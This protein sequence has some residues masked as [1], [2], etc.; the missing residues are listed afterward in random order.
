M[1]RVGAAVRFPGAGPAAEAPPSETAAPPAVVS[2]PPAE[3]PSAPQPPSLA[4]AGALTQGGVALC[5]AAPGAE[6]FIAGES[7]GR[8]D[9][10]G[11]AVIGFNREAPASVR[12]GGR[13]GGQPAA[14]D[15]VVAPPQ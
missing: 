5:R 14:E 8:A 15:R 11:W 9:A 13:A 7:A 1:K 6:I 3:S 12:G 4:C 10:N 2:P